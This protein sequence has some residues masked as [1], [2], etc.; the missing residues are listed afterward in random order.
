TEALDRPRLLAGRL[1]TRHRGRGKRDLQGQAGEPGTA[2]DVDDLL[3]TR[4]CPRRVCG[5]GVEEVLDRDLIR[6]R[7]RR[8]VDGP[9]GIDE[10]S[11]VASAEVE[12][13]VAEAQPD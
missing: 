11:G 13:S 8:E 12:L 5:E 2:A 7:D 6:I 4:P 1:H 9:R 3:V 10:V